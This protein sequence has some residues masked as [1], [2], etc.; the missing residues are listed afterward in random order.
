MYSII[1]PHF[2]CEKSW[3]HSF[4]YDSVM[5]TVKLFS[6]YKFRVKVLV[7]D[8]AS[9]NLALLKVLAGYKV[10]Q[11]PVEEQGTGI[12]RYLSNPTLAVTTT[13]LLQV[14]LNVAKNVIYVR[15]F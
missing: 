5:R 13:I 14:V 12:E 8:G 1:G 9:S 4:L 11:I 6:L 10:C 7:C 2:A 15:T 3:D